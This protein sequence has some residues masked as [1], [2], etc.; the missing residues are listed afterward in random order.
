MR[1][2]ITDPEEARLQKAYDD[3]RDR[4]EPWIRRTPPNPDRPVLEKFFDGMPIT[5]V[6]D[7]KAACEGIGEAETAHKESER[8]LTELRAYRSKKEPANG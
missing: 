2:P 5:T 7:L 6:D 8:T 3:A 4:E 1:Y